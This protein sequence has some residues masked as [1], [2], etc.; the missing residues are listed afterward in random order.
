MTLNLM[1]STHGTSSNSPIAELIRS[2]SINLNALPQFTTADSNGWSALGMV[3][4]Y[5]RRQTRELSRKNRR[6]F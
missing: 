2:D 5:A 4:E 3:T 1:S 6:F